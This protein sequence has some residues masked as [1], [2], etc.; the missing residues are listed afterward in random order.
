[1]IE[2]LEQLDHEWLLRIND[3][4]SP[5]FDSIMWTLSSKLFWIPGYLLLAY[6]TWMKSG[7]RGLVF[8]LLCVSV[9]ILISDSGSNHLFKNQFLRY[10]PCH[11]L[12]LK[13]QLH[14]VNQYCGG[15][16]GFISSHAANFFALALFFSLL[17]RNKIA[18]LVLF[19]SAILVAY[20]RVYLGVHYPSDVSVGAV[21]GMISAGI[22][23]FIFL[24]LKPKIIPAV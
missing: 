3:A 8:I 16:Y 13:D 17:I 14:L 21:W 4:H 2:A 24:K 7:W 12:E 9:L 6:W 19:S 11:N 20:S 22:V 1:M 15:Q 23:Y 5:A 10:R 18:T